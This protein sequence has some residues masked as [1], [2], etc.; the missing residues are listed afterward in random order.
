MPVAEKNKGGRP[1][2][3]KP[4]FVAQA[5]KLTKIGAIDTEVADFFGIV[6]STLFEWKEK[7]PKFSEAL[8]RGKEIADTSV[9]QALY[10]RAIGHSHP[11]V[12]IS[13][14]QGEITQTDITKHYPPDPTSCIFWL[15]NRDPENWRDKPE[16]SSAENDIADALKEIADKLPS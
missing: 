7:Y 15:K 10:H 1:S 3:Y 13:N 2:K 11:D 8:K 14:Y 5:E 6:V 9:K 4:E 12:H 16:G